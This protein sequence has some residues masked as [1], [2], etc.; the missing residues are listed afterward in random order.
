VTDA[1]VTDTPAA[2]PPRRGVT[3]Q[4][5]FSVLG[6]LGALLGLLT[7]VMYYFGWRRSDVQAR[8]MGID[9]SLFGFSTQEYVLRSISSLFLPL[10]VLLAAGLVALAG[11]ARVQ[12][13]LASPAFARSHRRQRVEAAAR[14][15]TAGGAGIA[16][17][18]ILFAVVAG[19]DRRPRGV[20]WLADRLHDHQY[21]VPLVQVVATLVA[22]YG[23]W[24]SGRLGVRPRRAAAPFWQSA[25]AVA[26]VAGTVALGGFW[27]LEEYASAVGR[28][29]AR[30]VA[31]GVGQ[32]PHA[33]VLGATP[34][35]IQAP[36][37]REERVGD[38]GS[39]DVRYR[40]TGL[41]LLARSGGKVLLV[42]DG[43][44]PSSGTVVVLPD[45]PELAWQFS[46]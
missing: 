4:D 44:S 35:G 33:V 18:C 22:A 20:G 10:L 31:A 40:T 12:R 45:G 14:W 16:G 5:V 46:R 23:W 9:V 2:A 26:L 43:W 17:L 21:A 25:L 6:S 36:G 3:R 39:P 30:Q 19:G 38:A 1:I 28:G 15:V 42:H 32:L 37:V 27:M 7:A 34:L 11:Q 13:A 8:E 41:R 24:L 29:Y